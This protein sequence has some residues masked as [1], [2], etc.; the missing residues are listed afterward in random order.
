MYPV[1]FTVDGIEYSSSENYYQSHKTTDPNVCALIAGVPPLESKR[2]GRKVALRNDWN[3]VKIN[4]MKDSLF[5][6]F[7]SDASLRDKLVGT[8]EIELIEDNTWNDKFW[9]VSNG[10]GRNCLGK[11]LMSLRDELKGNK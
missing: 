3:E 6:K 2:L 4:I 9:G 11:L 10:K 1:S 8:G 5:Y 7:S